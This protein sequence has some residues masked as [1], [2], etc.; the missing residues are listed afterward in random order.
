MKRLLP[1]IILISNFAYSQVNP[2]TLNPSQ[3]SIIKKPQHDPP[4]VVNKYT[5]VLAYD[6]CANAITVADATFY[7]AGDTVLMIQMKGATI[8]LTNTASF[9]NITSIGNAGNYEYARI[10]SISGTT[11][12]LISNLTRTYN[13]SGKVQLVKVPE[14]NNVT[15][16]GV[17]SA[18]DWNG[19][20]GGVL[21]FDAVGSVTMNANIDVTGKGFTGGLVSLNHFIGCTNTPD[22]FLAYPQPNGLAGQKGEGITD[23]AASFGSARGKLASGGGGGNEI[24]SGAG[25]GGNYGAGGQGGNEWNGCNRPV[26][27]VGALSLSGFIPSNKIFLGGG[28]GGGQQNDNAGTSGVDGGGAVFIKASSIIGNGRQIIASGASSLNGNNDG[29]GGGG[30]GG[31]VLLT[32]ST[33][34]GALTVNVSGGKGGNAQAGHGGGA[35]AGGGV[36][37]FSNPSTP[38]GVTANVAGGG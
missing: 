8:D 19:T 6:I 18:S 5:E 14:Y 32:A 28:G 34:T 24:N 15:I 4:T 10:A 33:Y 13:V 27:G 11:V 36:V 20:I 1:F 38:A 17:L 23:V 2:L 16:T 7:N 9:G 30:A 12:T 35:G 25:G 37:W 29:Q 31:S 3:Q 21:A 22:Y 26:G